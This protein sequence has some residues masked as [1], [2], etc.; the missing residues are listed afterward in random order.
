MN[1]HDDDVSDGSG[2]RL[3]QIRLQGISAYGY[4]GVLD[5]ERRDGQTFLA[6]V[7][8]HVDTRRAAA[9]DDLVHTV[10]YGVVAEQVAAVLSGD[11]VDLV[12]TVAERIAATVLAHPLVQAVDVAVHKPQ[13]PITVPFG[14]VVVSIRR[15]RSKLPAAEPYQGP[16]ASGR[17]AAPADPARTHPPTAPMPLTA[18]ARGDGARAEGNELHDGHPVRESVLP[19]GH[20]APLP[21]PSGTLPAPPSPTGPLPPPGP[22]AAAMPVPST[23]PGGHPGVYAGTHAGPHGGGLEQRP[24]PSAPDDEPPAARTALMPPVRWEDE[25]PTS[26]VTGELVVDELDQAPPAPVDVVLALGANVGPA[27]ETLRHAVADLAA[28]PGVEIVAV[29]PLARTAAVGPEQPDYLNA[30]LLARTSLGPRD[31]L[32]AVHAVEQRHGRERTE[33]WG[34]RTLDVD[35]VVYGSTTAVTDDLELPHP[36][37]HERAFVLA[38]WAQVDP[39]AVLPGLGGGPVA[40]LAATAPDREGVRWMALDWLTAPVPAASPEPDDEHGPDAQQP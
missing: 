37:A 31:L 5:H 15:D 11:P 17:R 26:P 36:R 25:P 39:E 10:H 30:V 7:V 29:S 33:R 19:S 22:A 40:Q 8:L 18:P 38:P 6:D 16:P 14:D 1:V 12:E 24:A 2:R 21:A 35:I 4:H 9:G 13:A 28:V 27:Q 34:P 3:D 23:P 20:L 32:R